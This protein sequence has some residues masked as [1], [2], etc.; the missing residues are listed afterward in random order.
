MWYNK[1]MVWLLK[2]PLHG[3]V[4]KNIM[5]V[6]YTG[7]KSGQVYTIPVNYIRQDDIFTTTS[8]RQRTWWRNLRGGAPVTIRVKGQD[9]KAEAI[10]V[11]DDQDV[12]TGLMAYLRQA[13]NLARYYN[14]GLDPEGR[15][16]PGD[17]AQTAKNRVII[18]TRLT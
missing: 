8:F 4:S 3:F 2:S 7:R 9:L 5:L 12:T 18:R 11:E 13:P 16:N 10:V 17:V 6:T 1:V 14:V 15:P